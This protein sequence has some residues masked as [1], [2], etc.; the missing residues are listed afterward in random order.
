VAGVSNVLIALANLVPVR[1]WDG[2]QALAGI[3]EALRKDA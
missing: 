3:R 1:G 2:G